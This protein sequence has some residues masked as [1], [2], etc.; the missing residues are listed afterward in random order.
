MAPFNG[1]ADPGFWV[2]DQR[3]EEF[4]L[5]TVVLALIQKHAHKL[6]MDLLAD[7]IGEGKLS[8]ASTR[9]PS[10]SLE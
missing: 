7:I 4:M 1:A 3:E 6:P 9:Y 2:N 8:Q 10:H 5:M